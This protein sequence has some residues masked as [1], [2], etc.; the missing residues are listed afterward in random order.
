MCGI[1]IKGCLYKAVSG[2]NA[3]EN[4]SIMLVSH[5]LLIDAGSGVKLQHQCGNTG[6]RPGL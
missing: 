1:I 2:D 3:A 4:Y 5:L 6:S